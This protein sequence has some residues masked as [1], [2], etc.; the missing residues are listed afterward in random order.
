MVRQNKGSPDVEY[1]DYIYAMNHLPGMTYS[2]LYIYKCIDKIH[3]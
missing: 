1:V 3:P 2:L